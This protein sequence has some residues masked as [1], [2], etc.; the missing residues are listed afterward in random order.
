M[1]IIVVGGGPAG[2]VGA[3]RASQLGAEVILV[4]K[5][6]LGGT[7]LNEGCIPT[8]S[9]L[10]TVGLF[11]E[12]KHAADLG[13]DV[14]D[15]KLNWQRALSRKEAIVKRLVAGV[16]LLL[17]KAGVKVLEG[18]GRLIGPGLVAVRH[19]D[20]SESR[21]EGDRVVLAL[22]SE[23]VIPPIRGLDNPGVIY[24]DQAL[25]LQEVPRRM[26]VIGGGVVGM[27][28]ATIFSKAGCTVT[29]VEMLPEIL[30][31]VDPELSRTLRQLLSRVGVTIRTDSRVLSVERVEDGLQ[32]RV[33]TGDREE[34]LTGNTVL[35]TVGR[36]PYTAGQGLEEAG[37]QLDRGRIVV[38]DFLE[39]SAPGV[40]AAGDVTGHVMLAH[41]AFY[42]GTVAA[43]NAILG[44]H[45]RVDYKTV[46]NAIY[47]DPEVAGVGLTEAQARAARLSFKVGRFP[48]AANGKAL[49]EN[50][51]SGLVKVIAS[52]PG[53]EVLGLHIMGPRAVDIIAEAGLALRMGASVEDISD[54]IHPHPTISEA[55]AEACLAVDG[56]A[57]H[58]PNSRTG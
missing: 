42:E 45:R 46:P 57:I 36:R 9:L 52:N 8:K 49:I 32:V 11:Y 35:V 54:T 24:S 41:V 7:C 30:P 5:K 16:N 48:L 39:T 2:Y 1:R 33:Q 18:T 25:S 23:S 58:V 53:G 3:I 43:E 13:I 38:D 28:M 21:L 20:G 29:I 50:G 31:P 55:V 17:K 4:E 27:E 47:T 12:M 40:F 51:G 19:A 37:V 10:H 14:G 22:G 34:T 15:V 44:K 6:A 26:I 56:R